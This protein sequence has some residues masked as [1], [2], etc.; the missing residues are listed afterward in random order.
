MTHQMIESHIPD[1]YDMDAQR[2]L[3]EQAAVILTVA[4]GQIE[5][6]WTLA[7]VT[8]AAGASDQAVLRLKVFLKRLGVS[9]H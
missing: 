6:F 3:Q 7:L 9:I 2:M 5:T 4:P 1:F 8:H